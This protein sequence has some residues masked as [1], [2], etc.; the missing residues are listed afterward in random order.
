MIGNRLL[1]SSWLVA[2]A[3]LG[4]VAGAPDARAGIE[5][6]DQFRSEYFTQTGD[7]ASLNSNG[8]VFTS[9]LFA[10]SPNLYDT[11]TMTSPG[12]GSPV[13]LV[14]DPGDPSVYSYGSSFYGTKAAMDTDFP[15]GAYAYSAM[16]GAGTDM[17]SV[18]FAVDDYPQSLPY[19][20]GSTYSALQGMNASQAFQF[21]FSPFVTGSQA[22]F[23]AIYFTL[24]DYT[25]NTFAYNSG[26]LDPSTLGF[27]LSGGTL[28]A[29]H[30]Y[31]YELIFDNRNNIEGTGTTFPDQFGFDYRTSGTFL[32]AVPEP[33]SLALA[34]SGLVIALGFARRKAQ[35]ARS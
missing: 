3:F 2:L 33:S 5:F 26:A 30:L 10:S 6:V 12:L 23:S 1:R 21:Q 9:R 7:G 31:G 11:V 29:G 20:D 22:D 32:T 4:V 13:S 19:L 27:T 8:Y 35:P 14:V 25:T 15:A 24:Y 17:A 16:N 28:Q 34:A 18:T